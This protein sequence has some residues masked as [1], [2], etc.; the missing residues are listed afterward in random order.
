MEIRSRSIL[1]EC[2]LSLL[3]SDLWDPVVEE[4]ATPPCAMTS[5][6]CNLDRKS[7]T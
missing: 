4:I 5:G 1:T 6:K 2:I 7:Q 3:G